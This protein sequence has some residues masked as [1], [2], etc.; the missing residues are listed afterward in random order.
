MKAIYEQNDEDK[1]GVVTLNR[2][3]KNNSMNQEMFDDFRRI[4][5]EHLTGNQKINTIIV[6]GKGDAFCAGADLA[7]FLK[8]DDRDYMERF[9]EGG[10]YFMNCLANAPQF[11]IAAVNGPAYGGGLEIALA[12][13]YIV[14]KESDKPMLGQL[15]INF[16][17]MPGS[18]ATQRLP[19]R[20]GLSIAKRLIMSGERIT[21]GQALAYKVVDELS[22]DPLKLAL[23]L[24]R[25]FKT[26]PLYSLGKAKEAI[27]TPYARDF[28]KETKY[29]FECLQREETQN[30]IKAFFSRK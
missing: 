21:P 27:C 2:P 24:S 22:D 6:T 18:G 8:L 19:L 15:E 23:E 16:G 5:D 28:D 4:V 25:Q 13:D 26:K 30:I 11:V 17:L 1:V 9:L 7:E 12:A 10:R 29:F 20:T 3:D 14:A